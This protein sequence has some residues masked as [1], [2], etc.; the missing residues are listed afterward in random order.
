MQIRKPWFETMMKSMRTFGIVCEAVR[1]ILEFRCKF[2]K[3]YATLL[4][5]RVCKFEI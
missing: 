3:R 2:S 4:E 1:D 5:T